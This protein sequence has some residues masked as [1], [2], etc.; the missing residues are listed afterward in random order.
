MNFEERQ[1]QLIDNYNKCLNDPK[2][3]SRRREFKLCIN[4]VSAGIIQCNTGMPSDNK[5]E[6]SRAYLSGFMKQELASKFIIEFAKQIQDKVAMFI[7][8]ITEYVDSNNK[9]LVGFKGNEIIAWQPSTLPHY[10]FLNYKTI[11]N[12]NMNEDVVFIFCYNLI[13]NREYELFEDIVR[14]LHKI[15]GSANI[16]R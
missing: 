5:N 2:N 7:P 4:L 6:N 3:N 1:K 8:I 11:Q 13:W 9:I 15:N 14:I 16:E 10:V 12:I